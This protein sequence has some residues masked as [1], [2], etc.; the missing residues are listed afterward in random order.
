MKMKKIPF[1]LLFLWTLNINSQTWAPIGAKWHYQSF[2]IFM[3][4]WYASVE[5]VGDSIIQ[6]KDCKILH[7]SGIGTCNFIE[8]YNN[9]F[10]NS[11]NDKVYY[12]SKSLSKFCLLYDFAKLPGDTLYVQVNKFLS[13]NQ[14][15][16]GFVIDSIGFTDIGIYHL[17]TQYLTPIYSLNNFIGHFGKIIE[18]IGHTSFLFPIDYDMCDASYTGGLLCYNDSLIY[19]HNPSVSSSFCSTIG[20]EE[21]NSLNRL[22]VFPN[23]TMDFINIVSDFPGDML[24]GIYNQL[25][26]LLQTFTINKNS[27]QIDIS[28]LPDGLYLL[29]IKSGDYGQF[30]RRIIKE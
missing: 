24:I 23:P 17:R 10:L 22:T 18:Y 16:V 30:V 7:S 25:G 11:D 5:S 9:I 19:Y 3:N 27:K 13:T 6:G 29:N 2:D 12:Y 26:A 28:D 1:I 8:D 21:I 4:Q 15:S 14:D 20:V